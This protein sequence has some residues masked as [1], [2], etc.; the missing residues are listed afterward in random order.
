V[1]RDSLTSAAES[2][3]SEYCLANSPTTEKTHRL[4]TAVMELVNKRSGLDVRVVIGD[5]QIV[6]GK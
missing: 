6:R 4:L 1:I 2:A 3:L 5:V